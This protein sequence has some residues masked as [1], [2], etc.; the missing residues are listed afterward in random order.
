MLLD[1]I[2]SRHLFD[3]LQFHQFHQDHSATK[4]TFTCN[5]CHGV[6]QA[7]HGHGGLVLGSKNVS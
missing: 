3:V 5:V 7:S 2:T 6:V 1:V 4:K